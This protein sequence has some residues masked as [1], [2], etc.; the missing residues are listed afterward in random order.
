MMTPMQKLE[1]A[2]V[3]RAG[4]VREEKIG[5]Y[6]RIYQRSDLPALGVSV[7]EIAKLDYSADG[8]AWILAKLRRRLEFLQTGHWSIGINAAVL[9]IK[10]EG[11]IA[12]E[13]MWF[14]AARCRENCPRIVFDGEVFTDA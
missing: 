13:E 7:G 11:A 5:Q 8:C 2:I 1:A 6:S 12:A 3:K 4:E 9:Q 10:V 14:R